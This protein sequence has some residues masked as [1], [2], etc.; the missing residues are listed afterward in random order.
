MPQHLTCPHCET[1]L[2]LFDDATAGRVTC[3][4]CRAAIPYG[5]SGG[6]IVQA[7]DVDA[8]RFGQTSLGWRTI[9]LITFASTLVCFLSGWMWQDRGMPGWA[10]ASISCAGLVF[11]WTTS[12]VGGY[13]GMLVEESEP[14]SLGR[15]LMSMGT[16][17]VT[18]LAAVVAVTVVIVLTLIAF[19]SAGGVFWTE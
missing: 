15:S 19:M 6:G 5:H 7:V 16:F 17:V 18:L 11:C 13:L 4:R 10:L 14:A 12:R 8:E 2:G 1:A 3:P 9:G